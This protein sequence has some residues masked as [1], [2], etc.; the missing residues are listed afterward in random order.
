LILRES[1]DAGE[2]ALRAV[3]DSE[4]S[5]RTGRLVPKTPDIRLRHLD[6]DRFWFAV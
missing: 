5:D 2:R 6:A 3:G 1:G 4:F